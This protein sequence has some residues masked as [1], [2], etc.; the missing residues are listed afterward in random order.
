MYVIKRNGRQEEVKFDKITA[1]IKKLCYGL[2]ENFVNPVLIAMKVV[3]GI[4]PGVT[5]SEL[6]NLAA[7]TAASLTTKHPDYALLA[8]RIAVSN[9]HKNTEKSFSKTMEM[10]YTYLDPK[11]GQKAAL[12][13]DDVYQIIKDN[14]QF[15]D[16][17]I[18][19]DRDFGYDYFGFKTLERS[20]LLKLHGKVAERPQHMLMRVAVGIHK[21]DV[22]SVIETYNLMSERWFTHATP[23][24]FNAGT[25]KPQMSSCFLL[26]VKDD[27]IDGIYDTLKN[28]AKISQ[29]AGGI[30]LSIH[31]IRATGSYI[32]G[33]NGT[34]N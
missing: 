34:S 20:Y 23:T 7:E 31:N 30:G 5:T 10:L 8:S 15:L 1:R 9:L 12:I 3:K 24:L 17:S 33:T 13:A 14:A 11:T 29:S 26:T 21:E 22:E 19:Y 18:I 25:P 4:Y 28:C 27:S 6:D 16:S 32:K 2:D